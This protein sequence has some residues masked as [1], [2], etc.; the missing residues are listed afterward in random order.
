[1]KGSRTRLR[2]EGMGTRMS[3]LGD[4]FNAMRKDKQAKRAKRMET[5]LSHKEEFEHQCLIHGFDF[6]IKNDGH[7]WIVKTSEA[8]FD[9]FPSSGKLVI[10]KQWQKVMPAYTVGLVWNVVSGYKKGGDN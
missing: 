4:V 6:A 7:H 9:W 8:T 1:M 10:D 3:E 2:A 5:V